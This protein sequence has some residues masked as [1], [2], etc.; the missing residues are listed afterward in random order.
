MSISFFLPIQCECFRGLVVDFSLHRPTETASGFSFASSRG[1][2]VDF[3]LH[4]PTET[5]SSFSFASSRGPVV[6]FSLLR[7]METATAFPFATSRGPVAGYFLLRPTECLYPSFSTSPEGETV[8]ITTPSSSV[9]RILQPV[10]LSLF[11]VSS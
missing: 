5:A 4:R 2:V 3:S 9:L 10:A 8:N 7:P 11:I 1:P 6:D